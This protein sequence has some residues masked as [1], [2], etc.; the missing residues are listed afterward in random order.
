MAAFV[1]FDAFKQRLGD[2]EIDLTTGTGHVFKFMLTNTTPNVDTHDDKA[3]LTAVTGGTYADVT[4]THAWAET[5]AGS[6]VWRF[7]AGADPSWTASGSDFTQARYVALFD[8]THASDA[9]VG[10]FDYGSGFTVP[11]GGSFTLNLDANFEIFTLD[12]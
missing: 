6:G 4:I 12:G 7:A 11:N 9:L 3:D 1:F 10:Y 2:G 8:D 5:S